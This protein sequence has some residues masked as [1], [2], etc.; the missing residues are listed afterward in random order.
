MPSGSPPN[1]IE[2][3]CVFH[4]IEV[5]TTP[6]GFLRLDY[7]H[8]ADSYEVSILVA[9]AFRGRGAAGAAL[10]IV[11]RLLPW[12]ELRAWVRPENAA[13]VAL[14]RKAGYGEMAKAGE[15]IW[16]ASSPLTL[17]YAR[18]PELTP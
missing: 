6:A 14:F 7:R 17:A 18:H 10:E 12:A 4:V 5:G 9:Q 16:F 2:L 3:A 8:D 15:G 1:S 13:S 11:R